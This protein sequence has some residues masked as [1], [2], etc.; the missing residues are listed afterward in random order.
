MTVPIRFACTCGRI[1]RA[2]PHWTGRA[3][4]CPAC[5]ADVI[6][7]AISA[8]C[9]PPVESTLEPGDFADYSLRQ[10]PHQTALPTAFTPTVPVER[11]DYH[12]PWVDLPP[13]AQL[14]GTPCPQIGFVCRMGLAFAALAATGIALVPWAL[15]LS[16]YFLLLLWL[17]AGFV[18]GGYLAQYLQNVRE[19]A[20]RGAKFTDPLPDAELSAA[21]EAG[22]RWG[23]ALVAGPIWFWLAATWYALHCGDPRPLDGLVLVELL[24]GGAIAWLV[25]IDLVR[26]ERLSLRLLHPRRVWRALCTGGPELIVAGVFGGIG[27]FLH[28]ALLLA[29]L[30]LAQV[31]LAGI[32]LLW[33]VGTSATCWLAIGLRA[34]TLWKCRARPAR[35]PLKTL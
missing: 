14:L 8:E 15:H 20:S 5:T 28:A 26:A 24:A 23:I 1:L 6:V 25:A 19:A 29:A 10:E 21:L 4:H 33:F 18:W 35:Q 34:L 30:E 22:R 3:G 2:P 31:S 13:W 16:W 7:P 27:L 32:A 11:I 17:G 9:E 12:D